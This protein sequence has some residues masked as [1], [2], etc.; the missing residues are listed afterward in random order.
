MVQFAEYFTYNNYISEKLESSKDYGIC[1]CTFNYK[2]IGENSGL[3]RSVQH[4]DTD[5]YRQRV[6]FD[7]VLYAGQQVLSIT[8]MKENADL[9][10]DNEIRNINSW[11]ID[12]ISPRRLTF[13]NWGG[14]YDISFYGVFV[15]VV[16]Q[17]A[18][19]KICGLT[20]S[21]ISDAPYAFEQIGRI[22]TYNGNQAIQNKIIVYG[23]SD[24]T[25]SGVL[26]IIRVFVPASSVIGVNNVLMRL[27][28]TEYKLKAGM[29]T[30][31]DFKNTIFTETYYTATQ[32][33]ILQFLYEQSITVGGYLDRPFIY[34]YS[35][36]RQVAEYLSN[37]SATESTFND[38][39]FKDA[40]MNQLFVKDYNEQPILISD[41][42]HNFVTDTDFNGVDVISA[43]VDLGISSLTGT[44]SP[45]LYASIL[46]ESGEPIDLSENPEKYIY[47]LSSCD[48]PRKSGVFE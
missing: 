26:P 30:T 2:T 1:T 42:I 13:Y 25:M 21:F 34:T 28:E 35:K 18:G 31:I 29:A 47:I 10:T 27:G 8:V 40:I 15:D 38:K 33:R 39:K 37:Y 46:T 16:Y 22:A 17:Y 9:F 5:C 43:K 11:L 6:N 48:F 20:Y 45:T 23:R 32:R 12:G 14:D 36:Y 7:T 4:E 41:I 19:G 3:R 44:A 24:D